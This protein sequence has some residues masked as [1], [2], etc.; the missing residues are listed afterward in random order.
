MNRLQLRAQASGLRYQGKFIRNFFALITSLLL[1]TGPWA[2]AAFED[3]GTGAR[4]SGLGGAYVALGDDTLSLLYNPA[5]LA[6]LRQKEISSEYSQLYSG[7]TDGSR[8]GQ[9]FMGLGAPIKRAG[10]LAVGWKHFS[11]DSLYSER[12]L[13]VG[14]GQWL[15]QRLAL[16]FTLKQLHHS[17]DAP[18]TV[19]DDN[20]NIQSGTPSLFA[21]EGTSESSFSGDI[22]ILYRLTDR[23]LLGFSVQDMNEPDVALDPAD[24][25]VVPRTWRMG[26]AYQSAKRLSLTGSLSTRKQAGDSR[27]YV[28]IGG[29]EK[30]WDP[31]TMGQLGVRGALSLGTREF[32]QFSTGFGYRFSLFEL[33]YAFVFD[34]SGI[35]LGDTAGT[36]RVSLS[37]RFGADPTPAT[38]P[39][40]VPI[41]DMPI[42]IL[43]VSNGSI[44][45]DTVYSLE[46]GS[47][48]HPN[49]VPLLD[50]ESSRDTGASPTGPSSALKETPDF[51]NL[52]RQP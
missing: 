22:G 19:V 50:L 8:L 29:A 35:V 1:G 46:Q 34:L 23:Q 3:I 2:L 6:R 27:D 38:T 48:Q 47:G 14:Y 24:S 4:A 43:H 21:E 44:E 41:E 12:T 32:R 30:W 40:G 26:W 28:V 52:E 9:Y 37:Y 42:N 16:G 20:G 45:G 11:L 10:T 36:H 7:L 31:Y 49:D 51:N 5:G 13:A 39:L 18:S 25:D 17:F 33:N 15:S